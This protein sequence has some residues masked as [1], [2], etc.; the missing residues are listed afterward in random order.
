M[1]WLQCSLGNR[2]NPLQLWKKYRNLQQSPPE[3]D[4]NTR[5]VTSNPWIRTFWRTKKMYYHTRQMLKKARQ[6]KHG[7]HPM[8]LSRWYASKTY[9]DSLY[10]HRVE[11]KTHNV[12]RQN[13]LGEAH[14]RRHKSWKNSK[15]EALDSHD[16]CRRTSATTQSTTRLC[17]SEKRIQTIARRALGKDPRRIHNHSSQST[18]K[19]AKRTTIRG[20]RRT[21][22]RSWPENS[23][24]VLQ[25]SAVKLADSFV[26]V[27]KV[28]PNPLED[29][30]LEFLAFFKPWRLVKICLRVRTGFGCLEKNFQPTDR[31]SVNITL[32]NTARTELHSVITFHHANTRGSSCKAQDCTSLCPWNKCHPRVVSHSLPHWH[33]PRAQVLS[34]IFHPLPSLPDSLT[35]TNKTL[36]SRPI[37]ALRCSTA[38]WRINTNPIFHRKKHNMRLVWSILKKEINLLDPT[39]LI[40]NHVYLGCTQREAKVDLQAVQSKT[41]FVQKSRRRQGRLTTK[42]KR[43]K[44]FVGKITAWSYDMEGHAEMCF[45]RYCESA[46]NNVSSLQQVA[47]PCIDSHLVPPEDCETT[48]KLSAVCAQIVLKCLFLTGTGRPDLVT[49]WN[50]A[51]DKR[52]L[53]LFKYINRTKHY[54]RFCHVV[55]RIA[56]VRRVYRDLRNC[57]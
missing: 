29:K 5:D 40:E 49:V 7:R 57:G 27:V 38:E 43:K 45:E 6:E 22:L 2:N 37:F 14:L 41:E 46:K 17:S 13:R 30:Q 15:F 24:E 55:K 36:N 56:D 19:T 28:R 34:P 35:S 21:R 3:F 52:L 32:T 11:R 39:P 44:I 50:N 10:A 20:Q 51:C 31:W 8:I 1:S 48:G 9:R 47:T 33:W 23:L 4:Q 25:R 54:R 12:V 16:K 18:K 26:I 42:I 53:R